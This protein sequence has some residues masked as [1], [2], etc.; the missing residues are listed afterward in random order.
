MASTNS[1]DGDVDS[2]DDESERNSP[3]PAV[4]RHIRRPFRHET[5]L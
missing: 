1:S 2:A 5:K 3:P 4:I